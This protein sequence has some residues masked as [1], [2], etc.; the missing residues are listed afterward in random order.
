M[1]IDTELFKFPSSVGAQR[2]STSH[3]APTELGLVCARYSYKH[4]APTELNGFGSLMPSCTSVIEFIFL[5][6]GLTTEPLRT[7]SNRDF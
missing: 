6:L 2:V 7:R 4:S 5:Q 1:F 3:F